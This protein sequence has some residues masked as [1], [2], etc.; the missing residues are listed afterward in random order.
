MITA[1]EIII[2]YVEGKI[3]P[4]LDWIIKNLETDVEVVAGNS[5][6]KERLRKFLQGVADEFEEFL[7]AGGIDERDNQDDAEI[8]GDE[9]IIVSPDSELDEG[10]DGFMNPEDDN[11]PDIFGSNGGCGFGPT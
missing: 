10:T 11:E 4:S 1:D 6:D 9:D 5:E 7:Q 3:V 8:F 2:K